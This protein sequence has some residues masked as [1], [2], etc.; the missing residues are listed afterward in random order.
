MP[1]V[2][3]QRPPKHRIV[4][5]GLDPFT[6]GVFS[7]SVMIA[8]FGVTL[9]LFDV[10]NS[11]PDRPP[12]LTS[13]TAQNGFRLLLPVDKKTD[14]GPERAFDGSTSADSFWESPGPFPIALTIELP[15]AGMF[16]NYI[17]RA[18][19]SETS[20]M[21]L[22]WSVEGSDS[23]QKWTLLDQEHMKSGWGQDEAKTFPLH[24]GTPVAQLRFRFLEGFHA[25]ILR[26]YGIE[27]H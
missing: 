14:H 2:T 19:G 7:L 8:S 26:I 21:P 17:L 23:N 5:A 25:T 12:V 9:L 1:H 24:L 20:R 4:A 11:D 18:G 15:Q 3:R 22:A 16:S 10:W 27:V 13:V 6:T